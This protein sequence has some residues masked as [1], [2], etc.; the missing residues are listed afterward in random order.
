MA[1]PKR[2]MAEALALSHDERVEVAE[3]L[4][5][6]VE[7]CDPHAS[8][9]DEALQA[10]LCRRAEEVASGAVEGRS[11]AEVRAAIERQLDL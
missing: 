11:W 6:S 10:E 1:D 5:D 8:L 4:L 2:V 3:R 7:G 9:D